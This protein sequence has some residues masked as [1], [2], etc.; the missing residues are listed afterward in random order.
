LS[1]RIEDDFVKNFKNFTQQEGLNQY[2]ID[3]D[4]PDVL[5]GRTQRASF[6]ANVNRLR[7]ISAAAT[8]KNKLEQV[9]NGLLSPFGMSG[10]REVSYGGSG[11]HE[12]LRL[13]LGTQHTEN[14]S[15]SLLNGMVNGMLSN[16]GL[17][18]TGSVESER[19][20]IMGNQI[21][22]RGR[23]GES[24]VIDTLRHL[25][26]ESLLKNNPNAFTK[27][28]TN[29]ARHTQSEFDNQEGNVSDMSR[30]LGQVTTPLWKLKRNATT[31][32]NFRNRVARGNSF[33]NGRGGLM[34]NAI[35]IIK[36]GR[37]IT[38][39]AF[40]SMNTH[41]AEAEIIQKA[42]QMGIKSAPGGW[43]DMVAQVPE[44]NIESEDN[45]SQA[46]SAMGSLASIASQYISRVEGAKSAV[47]FTSSTLQTA[48][49]YGFSGVSLY[50]NIILL[51]NTKRTNFSNTEIAEESKNKLNLTNSQ[52]F[53]IRFNAT[54]GDTELQDR[55]RYVDQLEAMSSGTSPL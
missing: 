25:Q 9:K 35:N 32:S 30:F 19:L 55:F 44:V 3:L 13:I 41:I 21:T 4:T 17:F 2:R 12:I 36:G 20:N 18:S 27:T 34:L 24:S 54:R 51:S 8:L 14:R 48:N 28:N 45:M 15:D 43:M 26:V 7:K 16:I 40:R 23:V 52:T 49:M 10:D 31:L 5:T 46:L 1:L 37:M 6:T 22:S 47:G 29:L 53:A 39:S 50:H 42:V 11:G 33:V 38:S